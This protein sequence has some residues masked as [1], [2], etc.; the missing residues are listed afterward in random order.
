[1]PKPFGIERLYTQLGSCH[2]PAAIDVARRMEEAEQKKTKF[3][4]QEMEERVLM[5]K[6]AV[7]SID[8]AR[9]M[10]EAEQKKRMAEIERKGVEGEKL[11]AAAEQMQLKR[12]QSSEVCVNEMPESGEDNVREIVFTTWD[13]GS[14][15]IFRIIH[16]LFLTRF[17]VYLAVFNMAALVGDT[18]TEETRE[19]CLAELRGRLNDLWMHAAGAPVVPVGTHKDALGSDEVLTERLSQVELLLRNRFEGTKFWPHLQCNGNKSFFAVDS[20]SR[21]SY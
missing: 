8:V 1:M 11:A 10:E 18:A 14:Q 4:D 20:R 2:G 12:M 3:L 6:H 21:A 13:Y 16:H 17:A 7:D 19:G 9:R 5:A 15:H